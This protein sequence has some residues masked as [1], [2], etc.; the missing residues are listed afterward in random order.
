MC[1]TPPRSESGYRFFHLGE[2]DTDDG[3]VHVGRVTM[4][5][6]HA[7]LTASREGTVRHYDHTGTG[8][9]HV[10]AY[11]DEHG[12]VLAGALLPDLPAEKAR[13]MKGATVSGDWRSIGGKLE[14]VGMLAVNVPGFPVPRA[15][16]A[17][18]V[19]EDE[20]HTM[21]LVAAGLYTERD[22]G[23]DER[24]LKALTARALGGIDALVDCAMGGSE[25]KRRMGVTAAGRPFDL[26][27]HPKKPKG[28]GGGQWAAKTDRQFS[29]QQIGDQIHGEIAE[30]REDLEFALVQAERGLVSIEQVRQRYQ[31]WELAMLTK[32]ED[33][34]MAVAAALR[35]ASR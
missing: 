1:R 23:S 26:S 5:T 31:D 27:K 34:D 28:P 16:A 14:M 35:A 6:G 20:P 17:S 11:E 32:A 18:L 29:E 25:Q 4:D 24:K 33:F 7:P 13:R 9:A 12:I 15:M 2:V 19:V 22:P 3:P 30:T 21:A 10:R 8:A